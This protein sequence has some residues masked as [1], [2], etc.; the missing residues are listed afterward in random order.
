MIEVGVGDGDVGAVGG[1]DAFFGDV[2]HAAG[3]GEVGMV[4]DGDAESVSVDDAVGDGGMVGVD[5][6]GCGVGES[7]G[8]EEG[9]VGDVDVVC[10]D[11]EDAAFAVRGDGRGVLSL[12]L[13]GEGFGEDNLFMVGAVFDVDGVVVGGVVHGVGDVLVGVTWGAVPGS[14]GVVVVDVENG[15]GGMSAYV[16]CGGG[17]DEKEDDG[18]DDGGSEEHGLTYGCI[19]RFLYNCFF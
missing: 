15:Y 3:D 13:D 18:G 12:S 16:Q 17:E 6:D 4:G 2:D 11:G 14:L 7:R 5:V 10:V 19:W 8:V 9:K 1:V